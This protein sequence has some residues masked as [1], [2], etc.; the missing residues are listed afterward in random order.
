MINISLIGG[1]GFIGEYLYNL[2]LKNG[3]SQVQSLG[4]EAKLSYELK[5]AEVIVIMTQPNQIVV[6]EVAK[7]IGLSKVLKKVIYLSTTLIY[8]DS[9]FKQNE[10][11]KPEPLSDYEQAKLKEELFLSDTTQRFGVKL[12][13]ARL[14]NVYGDIKNK[15]IISK[16]LI[17]QIKSQ[18]PKLTISGNPKLKI[19][20]YIFIEDAVNLLKYLVFY[21]QKTQKEVFNIST[22][23]GYSLDQI[24]QLIEDL[25]S[26]KFEYISSKETIEKKINI[27]NNKKIL[28]KSGYKIENNIKEGIKKTYYRYLNA[29]I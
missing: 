26:K 20:D 18:S 17:S 3:E 13:I 9:P 22:G 6:D 1:N 15:G 5:N 27:G 2:L 25:S 11:V 7:V 10:T 29:L 21:N 28:K 4:R 8:P 23:S 24:I 19:R 16:I 12:S 14:S